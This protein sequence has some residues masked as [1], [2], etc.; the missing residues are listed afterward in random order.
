MPSHGIQA[1]VD[2]EL[3]VAVITYFHVSVKSSVPNVISKAAS[4]EEMRRNFIFFQKK[5]ILHIL[6]ISLARISVSQTGR[7]ELYAAFHQ[8]GI[9]SAK[10]YPS[11]IAGFR[12]INTF[13]LPL[14]V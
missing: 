11:S 2:L 1:E 3:L 7:D 10:P 9:W 8:Q 13:Y 5:K 12:N 14:P 4:T 6:G